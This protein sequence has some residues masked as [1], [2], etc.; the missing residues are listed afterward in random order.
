[1]VARIRHLWVPI[2][3][4]VP[5][6]LLLSSSPLSRYEAP[7]QLHVPLFAPGASP[8]AV[9][10]PR[11]GPVRPS[12]F[13]DPSKRTVPP[14]P[15]AVYV[16]EVDL[17]E[18]SPSCFPTPYDGPPS[19]DWFDL[20]P[21]EIMGVQAAARVLAADLHQVFRKQNEPPSSEDAVAL[22]GYLLLLLM[23]Y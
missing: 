4:H 15:M 11:A 7:A 19:V 23:T 8:T 13:A 20:V 6:P 21:R 9:S 16:N 5:A 22:L 18:N 10:V 2:F 12:P 17:N 14:A 3:S 1:V